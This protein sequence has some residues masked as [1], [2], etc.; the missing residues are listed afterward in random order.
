M[1]TWYDEHADD[2]NARRRAKYARERLEAGVEVKVRG[3]KPRRSPRPS[4]IH[5]A[6]PS[7]ELTQL[8]DQLARMTTR[9]NEANET[10]TRLNE[11]ITKQNE[12][13][14]TKDTD[15]VDIRL[16]LESLTNETKRNETKRNETITRQIEEIKARDVSISLL[17]SEL[18]ALRS[19][20]VI[21]PPEPVVQSSPLRLQDINTAPQQLRPIKPSPKVGKTTPINWHIKPKHGKFSLIR[22]VNREY[23][24][25]KSFSTKLEAEQY[26]IANPT[27]WAPGDERGSS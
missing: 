2:Y 3:P 15:L 8:R 5:V 13:I 21:D 12:T 9:Y 27:G 17:R 4:P 10:I 1:S 14:L 19:N 11:T 26:A 16:S 25:S 7:D 18:D 22:M 23:N 20:P 24:G 6:I